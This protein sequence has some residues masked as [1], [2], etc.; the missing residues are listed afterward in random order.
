MGGKRPQS[1][2]DDINISFQSDAIPVDGR[3]TP[4]SLPLHIPLLV[5]AHY[6]PQKAAKYKWR[7]KA[8]FRHCHKIDP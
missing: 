3:Q 4:F 8:D 6:S 1:H 5:L 7:I 2:R